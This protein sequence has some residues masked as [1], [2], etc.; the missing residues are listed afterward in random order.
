[1]TKSAG[2]GRT[3]TF[4]AL[5]Y[6]F[7]LARLYKRNGVS[8]ENALFSVFGVVRNLKEQRMGMVQTE[9]QYKYVHERLRGYVFR[10]FAEE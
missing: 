4:I 10:L 3:G 9:V 6:L 8:K 7:K 1:L 2:I 5:Y